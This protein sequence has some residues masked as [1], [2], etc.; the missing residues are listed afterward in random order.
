MVGIE[1]TGAMQWFLQS[2]EELGIECRIGHPAKI[3]AADTRKQKHDRRDA[4]MLLQL[5][6][7][8]RFPKLWMP[9]TEERESAYLAARS[10]SVSED[11]VASAEHVTSDC[12]ESWVAER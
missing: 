12:T 7:A 10:S 11:A 2:M 4:L 6:T 9:N 1:A 3:R 8:K 5:L